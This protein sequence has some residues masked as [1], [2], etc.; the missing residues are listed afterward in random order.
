MRLSSPL[1]YSLSDPRRYR[2]FGR[3]D[4]NAEIVVYAESW[5]QRIERSFMIQTWRETLKQSHSD[6]VVLVAVRSDGSIES[7]SFERSSGVPAI[8]EAIRRIID[9][10]KPFPAFSPVLARD[11]DVIEIRRSWHFDISVRLY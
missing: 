6:P 3:S 9:G 2:L 4:P 10:A 11:Y 1:P 8:D 7:V 5:S